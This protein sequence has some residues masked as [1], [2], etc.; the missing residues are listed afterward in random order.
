MIKGQKEVNHSRR[1]TLY[2]LEVKIIY[3][4]FPQEY[5]LS[6]KIKYFTPDKNKN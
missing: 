1:I 4:Y 2:T 5:D 6:L 3:E